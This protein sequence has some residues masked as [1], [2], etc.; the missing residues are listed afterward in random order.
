V[1]DHLMWGNFFHPYIFFS[2]IIHGCKQI[3]LN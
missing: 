2:F 3:S 1:W